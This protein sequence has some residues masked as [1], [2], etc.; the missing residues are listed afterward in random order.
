[1]RNRPKSS[2]TEVPIRPKSSR[3]SW[4]DNL[5]NDDLP[6]FAKSS[7]PS[8]V[9]YSE[10]FD[11]SVSSISSCEIDLS[12]QLTP[13]ISNS[14]GPLQI[15]KLKPDVAESGRKRWKVDGSIPFQTQNNSP[16]KPDSSSENDLECSSSDSEPEVNIEPEDEPPAEQLRKLA[17]D[18]RHK[19]WLE[20]SWSLIDNFEKNN[21]GTITHETKMPVKE[22]I[23]ES[24]IEQTEDSED[25]DME[26]EIPNLPRGK[27]LTLYVLSSWGDS[28]Y[29]GLNG[30][31]FWNREG[32]RVVPKH[33]YSDGSLEET[34]DP[35]SNF[36]NLIDGVNHTKDDIHTWLSEVKPGSSPKLFFRFENFE[37]LAMIRIW[38]FNRNRVHA[39][40]GVRNIVLEF[41][42]RACFSGEIAM[43]SGVNGSE[44]S[45]GDNILFT[46]DENILDNIA[47]NDSTFPN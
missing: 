37:T 22:I 15:P 10:D 14:F 16:L 2:A 29:I 12:A 39:N 44:F 26:I 42:S 32:K 45:W 36:L 17:F 1:L 9:K 21:K 13:R 27:L 33:V 46:K 11:S 3:K 19:N 30:L 7:N 40:R 6:S 31:E 23:Q 24:P 38:N 41:D 20:E 35:R 18:R 4:A 28:N 8:G 43:A 5:G 34:L 25:E 47:K